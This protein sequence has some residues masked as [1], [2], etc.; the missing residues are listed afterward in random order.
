MDGSPS[1]DIES[2]LF[3]S[4]NA[5]AYRSDQPGHNERHAEV[6][7]SNPVRKANAEFGPG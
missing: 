3:I 6:Q 2:R 1:L 5:S 7:G 4:A